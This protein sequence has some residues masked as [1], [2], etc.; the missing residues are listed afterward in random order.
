[1]KD[2]WW[3]LITGVLLGLLSAGLILLVSRP[4]RGKSVILRP[5]PTDVPIVIDIDGAVRQPGIYSLP[6]G[7]RVRDAVQAAGGFRAEANSDLI[8]EAALL[9]DGDHIHV[10][11]QGEAYQPVDG[12]GDRVHINPTPTNVIFPID[13]NTATQE[14]LEQLPGVGP[15]TAGK[16]IAYR[17]EEPFSIVEDIQK[18]PGIGPATYQK[19]R[20][21][22][23]VTE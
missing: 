4:P 9:E 3:V 11:V 7:S 2:K 8:N 16:I 14:V 12:A 23:Q 17:E 10:P 1:M 5:P 19:I 15:V 21:L 18:V 6:L 22:I 13:I 20:G